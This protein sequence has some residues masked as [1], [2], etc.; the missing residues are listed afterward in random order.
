MKVL[1][2][3]EDFTCETIRIHINDL[4]LFRD[5]VEECTKALTLKNMRQEVFISIHVCGARESKTMK[6]QDESIVKNSR[7]ISE[8]RYQAQKGL[9]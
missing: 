8:E 2:K 3:L 1:R 7:R 4:R 5:E 6:L 9:Q